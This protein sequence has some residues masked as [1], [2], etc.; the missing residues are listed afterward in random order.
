[1]NEFRYQL[2]LPHQ[3]LTWKSHLVIAARSISICILDTK[4]LLPTRR[5]LGTFRN[6]L[7]KARRHKIRI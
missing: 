4:Q 2:F 1:M 7:N 5:S 3:N 6:N